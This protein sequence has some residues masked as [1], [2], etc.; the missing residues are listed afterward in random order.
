MTASITPT[1]DPERDA[2]TFWADLRDGGSLI[3][4][5]PFGSEGEAA[6]Y[7]ARLGF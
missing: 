4:A 3:A 7:L 2:W 6:D 5:E 1:F